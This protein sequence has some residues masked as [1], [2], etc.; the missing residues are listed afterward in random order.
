[1]STVA[2]ARP[3]ELADGV[4]MRGVEMRRAGVATQPGGD[5]AV[6]LELLRPVELTQVSSFATI[7]ALLVVQAVWLIVLALVAWAIFS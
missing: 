5:V 3:T 1:M 7:A 2:A 6:E 4:E